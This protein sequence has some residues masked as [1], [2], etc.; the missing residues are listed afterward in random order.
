M[1]VSASW[2]GGKD[3]GFACYKAKAV[4]K[5]GFGNHWPRDIPAWE[6][7]EKRCPPAYLGV[8]CISQRSYLSLIMRFLHV[9]CRLNLII[10]RLVASGCNVFFGRAPVEMR[11]ARHFFVGPVPLK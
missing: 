7:A 2:S 3:A 8:S 11:A 9:K 1:K 4:F 10:E 6:T 5:Q